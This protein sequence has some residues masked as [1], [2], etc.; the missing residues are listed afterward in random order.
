MVRLLQTEAEEELAAAIVM[1]SLRSH[2]R[3]G[4]IDSEKGAIHADGVGLAGSLGLLSDGPQAM[5]VLKHSLENN[6]VNWHA[7]GIGDAK[8]YVACPPK[9][10]RQTW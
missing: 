8:A 2:G 6:L 9:E 1:M 5:R 10:G 7:R 3:A 4:S